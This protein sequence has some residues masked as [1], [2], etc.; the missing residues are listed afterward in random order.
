M[1]PA[2]LL[3]TLR[4]ARALVA[5][6]FTPIMTMRKGI[7][8]LVYCSA[9]HPDACAWSVDTALMRA[10]E[11]PLD[12]RLSLRLVESVL[13]PFDVLEDPA[14]AGAPSHEREGATQAFALGLFD[15][16]ILAAQKLCR[17]AA[18]PVSEAVVEAAP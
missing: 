6:G 5:R 12:Y 10:S 15:E 1:D 14:G 16:A 11:S 8:G 13:S 7:G 18:A 9:L 3:R 17:N 4:D 2:R